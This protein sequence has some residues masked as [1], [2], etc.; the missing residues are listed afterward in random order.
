VISD[1]IGVERE[2]LDAFVNSNEDQQS[3]IRNFMTLLT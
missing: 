2:L 3:L 1:Q